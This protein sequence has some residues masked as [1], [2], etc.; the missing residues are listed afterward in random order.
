MKQSENIGKLAEA[1]SS[2]QGEFDA[3]PL[4]AVNKFLGNQYADLGSVIET[5]KPILAKYQLAVSQLVTNDGERVGVTT[6][7]AHSS[8]EWISD[9]VTLPV[10]VEKGKS[11]AQVA[12]SI[13]TYLRRY[14]LSAILGLYAGD[15][16]D[17]SAGGGAGEETQQKHAPQHTQQEP[18]KDVPMITWFDGKEYPAKQLVV[19]SKNGQA[20]LNAFEIKFMGEGKPIKS[21]AILKAH[22][23]KYFHID[24][25]KE[26]TWE[27]FYALI[28]HVK[29]HVDDARWYAEDK[30]VV[31]AEEKKTEPVE[32]EKMPGATVDLDALSARWQN[33]VIFKDLDAGLQERVRDMLALVDAGAIEPTDYPAMIEVLEA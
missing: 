2:A 8:G 13:V 3:V 23:R 18:A 33:G 17:G 5:A 9:S 20:A 6:F 29:N 30:K 31:K 28:N 19:K 7:L 25:L 32:D 12:G 10:S 15:D 27:K 1:L 11:A 21:E 4:N 26:I 14:A 24:T 16:D 22:L